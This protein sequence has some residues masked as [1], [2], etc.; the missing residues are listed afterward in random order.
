MKR[1]RQVAVSYARKRAR[2]F[3]TAV[4]K[5]V[6][7]NVKKRAGRRLK[8]F[9]SKSKAARAFGSLVG[10]LGMDNS[11][12]ISGIGN[13]LSNQLNQGEMTVIPQGSGTTQRE[14]NR[15]MLKGVAINI[16]F[17][18][19]TSGKLYLNFAMLT[20][21]SQSDTNIQTQ[22]FFRSNEGNTNISFS[23][24]G[25]TALAKHTRSINVDKYIVHFHKRWKLGCASASG[26]YDNTTTN[27]KHYKFYQKINSMVAYSDKGTPTG[28]TADNKIF[29]V[30][31]FNNIASSLPLSNLISIP[32]EQ[33]IRVIYDGE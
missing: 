23:D 18:N 30:Y 20:P 16:A 10:K 26:N 9:A 6:Y 7:R 8:K 32:V 24:A 17:T 5:R 4:G 3:A 1:F 14:G 21:K 25:L 28:I 11:F 19:S 27:T 31:W 33:D 13:Q 22:N 2:T 29:L 12:R 15:I